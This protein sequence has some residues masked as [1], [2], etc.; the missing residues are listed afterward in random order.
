M[1]VIQKVVVKQ[2]L[3]EASKQELIEYY[4]EQK[5]QI[6]QEC[7]QLHFEQKK[8][9]RK[10]KFQPERVADYFT[11]EL[12]L[13]RE[14]KKLIQFQMEQLEVLELGSEIREREMETIIDVQVGDKWDKSIFDKTIVVKDG[15]IVEIR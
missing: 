4:T 8:M 11:H 9:E 12:D 2:I 7:D 3:T 1:E 5:R 14:K 10:S 13:R 15:I 6:E